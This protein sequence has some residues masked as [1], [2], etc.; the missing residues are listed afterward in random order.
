MSCDSFDPWPFTPHPSL[1]RVH[2][3]IRTGEGVDVEFK[4][5]R[6]E[7]PKTF[8]ETVCAFLNMDG[9]TILLGIANNG[10]IRG[11]DPKSV[12]R[13]KQGIANLSNNPQKLDPPFLLFPHDLDVDGKTLITIQVPASSQVHRCNGS[14]YLRSEDGDYRIRGVNEIAGLF[15]L[16]VSHSTRTLRRIGFR[17]DQHQSVS[18]AV[19]QG[20]M[21]N[22]SRRKHV[23]D[24]FTLDR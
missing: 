17:C 1:Q 24:D 14:V 7:L 18:S 22:I 10:Q 12:N 4:E 13:M 3:L 23:H 21:P 6:S 2:E 5:A 16:Q 11:V 19:C 20:C 8:F 9:G 15:N